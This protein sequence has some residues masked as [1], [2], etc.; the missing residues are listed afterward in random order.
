MGDDYARTWSGGFDFAP[1]G[2]M[3]FGPGVLHRLGELAAEL[4]GRRVLLVTDPGV[5]RA[6]HVDRAERALLEAGLECGRFEGVVENPPESTV[7]ACADFARDWA[8]HGSIDLI[9][10]LGGGSSLDTAKGCNFLLAGGGRMRDYWGIGKGSAGMLPMIAVPTTAGTGSECQSFALIAHE[11]THAKMACGDRK[12]TP[13]IALL[14]PELVKTQPPRVAACSAIDALAHALESAV[15]RRAGTISQMLSREAFC[16]I[17]AGLRRVFSGDADDDALGKLLLGSSLAGL[18][19]ENSMLGAAHACANPLTARYGTAHGQAVAWM[20]PAVI[21]LNGAVAEVAAQY[22]RLLQSAGYEWEDDP[23]E[24]LARLVEDFVALV[25]L[26]EPPDDLAIG[27]RE[28]QSLAGEAAS[29]WT[30]QFNP[31]PLGLGDFVRLYRARFEHAV[32]QTV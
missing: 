16:S 20:L 9:V 29:Q 2:R 18:A 3:V 23:A 11:V 27:E 28:W 7:E 4:G 13:A 10:G 5:V 24:Q 12:A 30:A 17:S 25:G 26:S 19:I 22:G 6:G 1:R 14:D 31:R 32:R 8:R 21:R 15:S